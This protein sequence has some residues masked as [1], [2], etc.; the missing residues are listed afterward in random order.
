MAAYRIAELGEFLTHRSQFFEIDDTQEYMR[1]RVQLHG[2]GIVLR[3]VVSGL[4]L[5]TKKQQRVR[6]GDLL[7]AEIDAK[8]GGF[9]IVP[10]ELDGAV[11]SSH[12][13]LFEI[14]ES[15]C[16]SQWLAYYIRSGGLTE[17]VAARGSTNY[18]AIRAHHVLHFEIPLPPLSEQQRIVARIEALAGKIEAARGLR[19]E[20]ASKLELVTGAWVQ[21]MV[22]EAESMRWPLRLLNEVC[23]INPSRKG[24]IRLEYDDPV[25]FVPMQ[26]VDDVSG[27]I[28]AAERRPFGDVNKGHTWFIDG[29]VIFARI[30]PCMQ[31]GKAAVARGLANAT[32]FGST[33]FHV[34]RPDPALLD[35]DFL[36]LMV[37][38]PLF[39]EKA[40]ESFKGTAGHQR[41][42]ES[43]FESQYIPVPSIEEQRAAV[44]RVKRAQD[45]IDVVREH[46]ALTQAEL[47]ALLPAVLDRAFRGEL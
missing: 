42:P 2:K 28:V 16:L 15:K 32:G 10:P 30:T 44:A 34:F 19:G 46:Q 14:D 23:E 40:K 1:V 29:D 20:A 39:R 41:V 4:S 9:G 33:E 11:V 18:A 7:V 26:A 36:H 8:L 17:Q 6:S 21:A 24:Q 31:N 47:D 43:F 38:R 12:Y 37:R 22:D 5:R 13:F 27:E 25:S 35:P 3:D 45:K